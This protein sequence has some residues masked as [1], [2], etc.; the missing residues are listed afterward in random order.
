[1]RFYF[2]PLF[3]LLFWGSSGFCAKNACIDEAR[4]IER[5]MKIP[6]LLLNAIGYIESGRPDKETGRIEPW[7]WTVSAKGK[8]TYHPTK[9]EAIAHVSRL[10]KS[11]IHNIDVGCMQINLGYHGKKFKSLHEA[12]APESNIIYAANFLKR[13]KKRYK[14]WSNAM[15]FYHSATKELQKGYAQRFQKALKICQKQRFQEV[16]AK[17]KK[18]AV[19]RTRKTTRMNKG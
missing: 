16:L 5:E 4:K 10:Q 9:K 7:P 18:R 8:G 11:G 15:K 17:N 6:Y 14:T 13:L 3:L 12:F 19:A 1:M 2:A